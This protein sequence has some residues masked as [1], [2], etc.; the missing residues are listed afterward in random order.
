MQVFQHEQHRRRGRELGE[1]AEHG[2]EHL[3]PGQARAVLIG[4]ASVA[5]VR[6]AAGSAR[7]GNVS[8]SRTPVD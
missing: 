1:Q 6:A 8:A 7:G 5:A 2:A 4:R 3:L